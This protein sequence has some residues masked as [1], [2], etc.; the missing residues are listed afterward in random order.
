MN[1]E[2]QI[3]CPFRFDPNGGF[4]PPAM[5][6]HQPGGVALIGLERRFLVGV[7]PETDDS[8]VPPRP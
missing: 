2:W 6:R 4:D 5:S 3:P 8:D 1:F 7:D